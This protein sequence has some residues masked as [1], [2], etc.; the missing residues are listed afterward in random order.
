MKD[1]GK[2]LGE[3]YEE[4]RGLIFW[5]AGVILVMV[6]FLI[7]GLLTLKPSAA[8]VKIGYGD[9][10]GYHGGEWSEMQTQGGYRDGGWTEMLAWPTMALVMMVT[11]IFIALKIYQ[12][13]GEAAAEVFLF[14]TIVI[15]M[16]AWVVLARLVGEG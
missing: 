12:K 10:G 11:H 4:H 16:F 6:G 3:I 1:F 14:I 13:K 9:I 7:Y 15:V 8:L 2:T 5:M